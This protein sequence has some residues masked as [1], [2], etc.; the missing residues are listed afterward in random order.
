MGPRQCGKTTLARRVAAGRRPAAFFDLESP[1]DLARLA[2]PEIALSRLKGLVVIDEIQHRPDLFPLLRVLSDRRPC[3]ARFLILGSVSPSLV[4]GAS[5]SLAG[6]IEFIEM[7]G[8]DPSDP[9]TPSLD[10]LWLRGGL[11]RSCLARTEPDSYAW[12]DNYVATFLERDIPNLGIR[13]PA[14]ALRRF[15]SM[16]AHYHGQIWNSSEIAG[17]MGMSDKTMRQYLD[18]LTGAFLVRQLQPWHENVGKRQVKSPKIYFRDTGLLHLLLEIPDARA[19]D[20]NPKIGASWEGF[21]LERTLQSL[22][23]LS[24]YFWATHS[25]AELD[26]LITHGGRRYGFE[27]K[28]ADAPRMT[29]SLLSAIETLNLAKAWI[30]YPGDTAYPLAKNVS[31]I[32]LDRLTGKVSLP[33]L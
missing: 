7:G 31:V 9:G 20:R 23:P 26:L 25:G 3:P 1:A 15:W 33:N 27:F 22:R 5:E 13:I 18:I 32:P 2:N 4:K 19:L 6:R 21:A 24:A 29:K 17:S 8:L 28:R 14:P 10:R 12:R 30:V 16:L 11:P